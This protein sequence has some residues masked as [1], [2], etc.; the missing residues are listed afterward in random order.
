M[1]EEIVAG[2]AKVLVTKLVSLAAEELIQAWNVRDDL[3]TLCEK[4]ESI[5]DLLS[6]AAGKKLSMTTVQKWF[7]KLQVVARRADAL[8]NELEYEVTRRKV[9]DRRKVLDFFLPSRNP[10]L[11]RFKVAHKIK[12]VDNSFD[13]IFKWGRDLGLQP[14]A[15]LNS[16]VQTTEIRVTP[17]FEDESLIVGRDDDLS[18]LVQELCRTHESDLPVIGVVGM[19]GQGKT[20]LARMVFNKDEA[21]H[22][23]NHIFALHLR[24]NKGVS[25]VKSSILKR[26]FE[27]VQVLYAGAHILGDVLPYLSR[28][29]TVLVLKS[30]KV[31]T[32]EMPS[33]LTSLKYLKYLDVSC[34][35]GSYRLP[36]EI[37]R[38]YNLQ[39][40]RVWNLEELP[41]MFCNL[42]N[43]RHI[44][45]ENIHA[46]TRCIFSG[47]DKLTC[48]QSLPHFV[49]SRVQNCLIEQ[50]GGLN[51]LR[52]KLD[53]YGLGNVTNVEA[54][55]ANLCEKTNI[56]RLLLDWSTDEDE[57]ERREFNDED[58]MEGLEPDANLKELT[59]VKFEGKNFASWMTMMTNLVK[60]T[61]KYCRRCEVL[62]PLGHLPKLREIKISHME[63]FKVIRSFSGEGLVSGCIELSDSSTAKSVTTM[64]PSLIKLTLKDLPRLKEVL[65]S[66]TSLGSEESALKIFPKLEELKIVHSSQLKE[67]PSH[68]FLSLRKL[69][70]A[71]L[72]SSMI[73]DMDSVIEKLLKNNS[74]SLKS[75]SLRRCKG[76]TCLNL[77]AGIDELK[78]YDCLDLISI[79]VDDESSGLK[80]LK[81]GEC[82]GLSQWEFVHTMKSTLVTLTLHPFNAREDEFPW[83]FSPFISFPNL[84]LLQLEGWEK[85]KSILPAEKLDDFC[86]TFPALTELDIIDFKECK[87][88]PDS[89]AKIPSLQG[90]YIWGCGKLEILP[91]FEE[92]H[93]LQWLTIRKCPIITER[94]K[95]GSRP[96]WFKIQH[97]PEVKIDRIWYNIDA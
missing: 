63:N 57:M 45:I 12:S 32:Y 54:R 65:E 95:K 85:I 90:I 43:L 49:V 81:I 94:C 30:T 17:P 67:I 96:E 52:G 3:E 58:V 31:T 76:L 21:D 59:I 5:H 60:I 97:I 20:T 61:I 22:E 70:M 87:A 51:D 73:Q 23:P 7:N 91:L 13:K 80:T 68:C 8:M 46:K 62:P 37:T 41:K 40:L 28:C 44:V 24:L 47:I 77:G 16:A 39:T 36:N 55:K 48:L 69:E 38:L 56:H 2:L 92:S 89:L 79:S 88:L 50:L 1:A 9:E 86:S 15:S 29:L 82:P 34:F 19:G 6:D 75:L 27:S 93:G 66:V 42:I 33:S 78:V 11:D 83:A 71:H 74:I 18:C 4:L 14:I 25:N 35:G 64:Y 10:V 53:L 26:N 84:K 72:E